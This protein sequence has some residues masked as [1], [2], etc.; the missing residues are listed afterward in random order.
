MGSLVLRTRSKTA[1]HVAVNVE[2]AISSTICLS[3]AP[4]RSEDSIGQ[5]S[6]STMV[7]PSY[8]YS[9]TIVL[10]KIIRPLWFIVSVPV[11]GSLRRS[12]LIWIDWLLPG[13][14]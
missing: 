5:R 9:R 6:L 10:D 2:I 14:H 12:W 7:K 11:I 1:R 3:Y 13:L 8:D 4:N